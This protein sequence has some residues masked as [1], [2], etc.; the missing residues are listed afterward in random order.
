MLA[1]L[2]FTGGLLWSFNRN[3][4]RGGPVPINRPGT[5]AGLT[6]FGSTAY[7]FMIDVPGTWEA[8]DPSSPGEQA[9]LR[10]MEQMNPDLGS[11]L[12][13]G[14]SQL[15]QSGIRL[16]AINPVEGSDGLTSNLF[17]IAQKA[18]NYSSSLLYQMADAF[19]AAVAEVGGTVTG[20]SF[21]TID[22]HRALRATDT[23][24]MFGPLGTETVIDQTVYAVGANG[25][26][27]SITLTGNDPDMAAIASTFSTN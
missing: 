18:S 27:Y 24:S 9:A 7:H 15:S 4:G 1:V 20:T 21:V 5:P 10:E 3:T 17:V 25:F 14:A 23:V 13:Q 8:I 12:S 2:G 19:P 22:G 16:V 11:S 6:A 26:V